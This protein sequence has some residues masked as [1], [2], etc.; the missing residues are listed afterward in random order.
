MDFFFLQ[1]EIDWIEI[2][3]Q[4]GILNNAA[5]R[6]QH[7]VNCTVLPDMFALPLWTDKQWFFFS[8]SDFIY[9]SGLPYRLVHMLFIKIVHPYG[10]DKIKKKKTIL[11][12]Q[13]ISCITNI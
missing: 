2:E 8:R 12:F 7:E 3:L 1:I 9:P 6:V 4:G 13:V 11:N 5:E 10:I